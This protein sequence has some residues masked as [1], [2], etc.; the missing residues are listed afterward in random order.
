M[1]RP[2]SAGRPVASCTSCFRA[3]HH[4]SSPSICWDGRGADAQPACSAGPDDPVA[5]PLTRDRDRRT[6]PAS[7]APRYA[8]RP[9]TSVPRR[10]GRQGG[11]RR[12][13]R[14]APKMPGP[15]RSAS[16]CRTSVRDGRPRL[17]L[18]E[19]S[20]SP[21]GRPPIRRRTTETRVHRV[22]VGTDRCF[23]DRPGSRRM[24][25]VRHRARARSELRLA[26]DTARPTNNPRG[27]AL[28][29]GPPHLLGGARTAVRRPV[30][31]GGA[32]MPVDGPRVP[33][34]SRPPTSRKRTPG[35]T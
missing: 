11:R 13:V 25:V 7:R 31:R 18:S 1:S 21:C 20:A 5:P 4:R 34:A 16:T 19:G 17:D 27:A 15:R 10:S 2:A 9:G 29:C 14:R 35:G 8:D 12:L 32:Q 23:S 24:R 28:R 30:R 6:R 22:A 3:G 26:T 33:N